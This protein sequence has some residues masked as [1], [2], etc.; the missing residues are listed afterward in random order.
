MKTT[1]RR[2]LTGLGALAAAGLLVELFRPAPMPVDLA[3]VERGPLAVTV[4]E[5]GQTRVLLR[6]V[7]AAPAAGRLARI[8]LDEGDMVVEGA[9][10]AELAPTPLD[11]RTRQQAE[12]QLRQ[13]EAALREARAREAEAAAALE[14]A[15]SNLARARQLLAAGSVPVAERERAETAE[16]SAA[17]E[18]AAARYRT[19]GAAAEVS[20]A[21]AALVETM[22]PGHM[23]E[24]RSPAAGRVLRVFEKSERVVQAGTP[25]VEVGDPAVLEAVV[26]VLSSDAVRVQPGAPMLLDD[27]SGL[28]P[29]AGRV[30]RIEPSGFTKV[31]PLGV[32]E[33]RV[34]V[35]GRFVTPPRRIADRY[36]V[37]A[38]IVLWQAPD[39]LK[40]PVGALFRT[41]S[42]WSVFV[43]AGGRARRRAVRIDHLGAAE[44]EV[45]GGL[46]PGE[47]VVLHPGDNVK[48]GARV[49]PRGG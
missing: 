26:D 17:D 44:A 4:D 14:Q 43:A 8:R 42:G 46:S 13:T 18:V 20:S 16:R 21:R 10:L 24:V 2:L 23:V 12:A 7:V 40:V 9:P 1:R 41:G 6:A 19:Q 25:L 34:N 49:R 31:S 39:V 28:P 38:Q 27:G 29:L 5:Q 47:R 48:D 32:E 30:H 45:T 3:P 22:R 15:R 35:I 36:R 33:Q 11:P 37:E